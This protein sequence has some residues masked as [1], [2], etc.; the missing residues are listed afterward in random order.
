MSNT[1]SDALP[2]DCALS[3]AID[4]RG[5]VNIHHQCAPAPA[6]S[7]PA[8]GSADCPPLG[9]GNTC[10]PPVAG[11][12]H[13]RSPAQKFA[14]R[15]ARVRVPSVLAAS[16]MHLVRRFLAGHSAASDL[17]RRAFARLQ[18]LP[19]TQRGTLACAAD[20]LRTLPPQQRQALFDSSLPLDDAKPLP[21]ELL[22]AAFGREIVKI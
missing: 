11:S 14:A 21:T 6:T 15:Q 2:G 20:R 17:E 1:R 7:P 12:K 19:T 5:D 9:D 18:A 4:A 3:I 10:L 13:K 16:T 8:T 22:T